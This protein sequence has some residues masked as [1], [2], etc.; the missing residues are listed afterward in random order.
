MVALRIGILKLIVLVTVL[1]SSWSVYAGYE[2]DKNRYVDNYVWK[3]FFDL[4]VDIIWFNYVPSWCGE[5]VHLG[6]RLANEGAWAELPDTYIRSF[7]SAPIKT[8]VENC[9][10]AKW[11]KVDLLET[12]ND[13][14]YKSQTIDLKQDAG[15]FDY[16]VILDE[17]A[18]LTSDT[19][20][21]MKDSVESAVQEKSEFIGSFLF[22]ILFL[23]LF[24]LIVWMMFSAG[25]G[26]GHSALFMFLFRGPGGYAFL[27]VLLIMFLGF[28]KSFCSCVGFGT[29]VCSGIMDVQLL[30]R[31]SFS[32][33][34]GVFLFVMV[35]WGFIAATNGGLGKYFF[36]SFFIV[37]IVIG[38][39]RLKN[40]AEG[41]F[42]KILKGVFGVC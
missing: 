14:L 21:D 16:D 27:V 1:V 12:V 37:V 31:T 9:P 32:A 8:V 40:P 26:T 5:T 41:F 20:N 29:E 30:F 42:T 22:T 6:L 15:S 24:L 11:L 10:S 13:K 7:L 34:M 33:A 17:L 39:D 23:G 18:K 19:V 38:I 35:A 3:E 28:L 25:L 36:Y 2:A 4:S